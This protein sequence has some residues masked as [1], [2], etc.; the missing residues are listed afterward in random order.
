MRTRP[1]LSHDAEDPISLPRD[2]HPTRIV[3]ER[4]EAWEGCLI[5]RIILALL[6]LTFA[7]PA[8]ATTVRFR[9]R[10]T[11][12]SRSVLATLCFQPRF[13]A[14]CEQLATKLVKP[15]AMDSFVWAETRVGSAIVTTT[16]VSGV[17]SCVLVQG[18][19]L[20][21]TDV[22]LQ[23]Q[24][25]RRVLYDL[26]GRRVQTPAR[27]GIYFERVGTSRAGRVVVVR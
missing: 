11:P 4:A 23:P 24:R 21:T 3:G 7:S 8:R 1:R 19:N 9:A 2:R 17:P 27:S 10:C 20:P 25:A 15:A 18:V 14:A 13:A 22:P 12:V 6:A 16:D 26:A 5:R